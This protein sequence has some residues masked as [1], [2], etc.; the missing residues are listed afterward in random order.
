VAG[1]PTPAVDT[2]RHSFWAVPQ[3]SRPQAVHRRRKADARG[4]ATRSDPPWGPAHRDRAP[5]S[6]V[7]GPNGSGSRTSAADGNVD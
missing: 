1:L 3:V 6:G 5:L 4:D 2:P 7:G